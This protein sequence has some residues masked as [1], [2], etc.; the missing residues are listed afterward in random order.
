MEPDWRAGG[1]KQMATVCPV[2]N[3]ITNAQPTSN[4]A[5]EGEPFNKVMR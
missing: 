3:A 5:T 1:A 4:V 2:T